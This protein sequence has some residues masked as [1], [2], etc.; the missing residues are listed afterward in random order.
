LPA[1]ATIRQSPA[2][3]PAPR[4]TAAAEALS[5]SVCR[6]LVET[7]LATEGQS[8]RI[9]RYVRALAG[10]VIDLGEYAR[11]KD[12][13]FLDLLAAVAPIYDIGL[14]AVP[15]GMLMKPD[16]LD[17]DEQSVVQTHTT[18]GSEV[19][20]NV[21]GKL[22]DELSFL[23]MAAEV[24]RSHHERWDGNGYPDQLAGA[25][26]PLSARMV[27]LVSVY[28]A[29]RARRPHRPPLA[30]SRAVKMVLT[31][32]TGQFDPTLLVGFAAVGAR[33]DA[34]HQGR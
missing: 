13:A 20:M 15:R 2:P 26:I 1:A 27:S 3:P 31:E 6:L 29:L 16:K 17:A 18:V 25:E 28:E 34:I 32:M 21:A 7:N 19:L 11:L 23:P 30:H 4:K 9:T 22:A 12:E 5:L 8:E 24:A 14:L 10:A 33:F